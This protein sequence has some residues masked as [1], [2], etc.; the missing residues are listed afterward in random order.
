[1]DVM[2][3]RLVVEYEGTNTLTTTLVETVIK[4]IHESGGG[5]LLAIQNEERKKIEDIDVV[6]PRHPFE[7]IIAKGH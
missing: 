1:M 2:R 4:E 3:K 7:Q 6:F 5:K